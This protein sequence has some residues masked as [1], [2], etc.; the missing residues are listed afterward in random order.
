MSCEAP[1]ELVRAVSSRGGVAVRAMVGSALVSEAARRHGTSP[2]TTWMRFS[3]GP[4]MDN[5]IQGLDRLAAMVDA[6]R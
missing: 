4:D 3:F 1:D 5:C 6:A 2:Y